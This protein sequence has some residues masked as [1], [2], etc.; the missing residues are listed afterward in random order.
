MVDL[1]TTTNKP[2]DLESIGLN[3]T[4]LEGRFEKTIFTKKIENLFFCHN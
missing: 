4:T 3:L 2:F 1:I